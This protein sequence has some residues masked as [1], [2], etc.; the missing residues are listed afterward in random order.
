M[1]NNGDAEFKYWLVQLGNL[2]YAGGLPRM[3]PTDDSFSHEFTNDESVAFPFG[4]EFAANKIADKCGGTVVPRSTSLKEFSD[5]ED[6]HKK[7]IH[8]EKE[9]HEEQRIALLQVLR[10]DARN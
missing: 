4:F 6:E 5:L 1:Q 10:K 8:S 3:G 9:W 2:Y 7:Y